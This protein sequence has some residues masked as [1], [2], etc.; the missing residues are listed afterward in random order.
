MKKKLQ[1][2]T[3]EEYLKLINSIVEDEGSE[4]EQDRL[5]EVF[6]STC[7]HPSGSDLIYYPE[8]EGDDEPIKILEMIK[9][10]RSDHGLP[11]FK[12]LGK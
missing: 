11:L 3:E 7:G 8:A 5:L 4:S 9:K 10:W 2:F 6:I 1:D 12:N